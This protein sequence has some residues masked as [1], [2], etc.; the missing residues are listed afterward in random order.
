M[1]IK[2]LF[3]KITTKKD[4]EKTMTEI[5]IMEANK[6]LIEVLKTACYFANLLFK[7]MVKPKHDEEKFLISGKIFNYC[8]GALSSSENLL[9]KIV[10]I[11]TKE[12]NDPDPKGE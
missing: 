3:F 2:K 9:E 5:E 4:G 6:K 1:E 10:Y 8:M 7:E 11:N 12:I